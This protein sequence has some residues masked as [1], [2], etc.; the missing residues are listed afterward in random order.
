MYA[1]ESAQPA[2]SATKQD[3]LALHYGISE[4]EYFS[5]HRELDVEHAAQ[6]RE[7]IARRLE[8]ADQDS[9]IGAA[10][11]ALEANWQLLDG[12]ERL[13]AAGAPA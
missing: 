7:L 12:V 3:G 8:G 10:E 6:A 13:I 9:L 11:A 2:I 1:I 5:L 4:A